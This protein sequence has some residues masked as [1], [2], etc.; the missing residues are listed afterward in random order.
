[1]TLASRGNDSGSSRELIRGLL[2]A[3]N[4][5]STA[6][7]KGRRNELPL[8][9][10]DCSAGKSKIWRVLWLRADLNNLLGGIEQSQVT[11]RSAVERVSY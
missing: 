11:I 8:M 1:M 10:L 4:R 6:V 9:A 7:R 2:E 5:Q 3:S